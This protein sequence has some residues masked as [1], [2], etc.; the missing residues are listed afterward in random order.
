MSYGDLSEFWNQSEIPYNDVQTAAAELA[1]VVGVDRHGKII[2]PDVEGTYAFDQVWS[3]NANLLDL[4]MDTRA[5][6]LR[7]SKLGYFPN[8]ESLRPLGG[9]ARNAFY[10]LSSLQR[11][12]PITVD[13]EQI[14]VLPHWESIEECIDYATHVRLPFETVFLDCELPTRQARD[15]ASIVGDHYRIFGGI[16]GTDGDCLIIIP[17]GEGTTK[18][19]GKVVKA[20]DDSWTN[21]SIHADYLPLGAV[22]FNLAKDPEAERVDDVFDNSKPFHAENGTSMSVEYKKWEFDLRWLSQQI[23]SHNP[24]TPGFQ[25][26]PECPLTGAPSPCRIAVIP[27]RWDTASDANLAGTAALLFVGAA[28]ILK[29]LYFLDTPNIEIVDAPVSRQ[30]R[31]QAERSG[32]TIAKTIFVRHNTKRSSRDDDGEHIDYS[33]RFEVR[34]HWKYYP[35]GTQIAD[36]RPDLLR[37]VPGRGM[38][39]KIW[40]P[41]FVKGDP[42]KPLVLKTRRLRDDEAS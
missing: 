31:R 9:T 12:H 23:E 20:E 33:H 8:E 10:V 1:Q 41:P 24:D 36:A 27:P 13:P 18:T 21:H 40:C 19:G 15:T 35:E 6:Q 30:V 28:E 42:E 11:A 14:N 7:A 32:A 38:C 4:V 5:M 39:R 34:G 37:Y 3:T 17:F 22:V 2:K 26:D 16:A 29:V 25:L